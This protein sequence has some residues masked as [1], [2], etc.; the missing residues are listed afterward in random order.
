[1]LLT[2]ISFPAGPSTGHIVS[3]SELLANVSAVVVALIQSDHPAGRGILSHS[4]AHP[5]FRPLL[6]LSPSLFAGR[7]LKITDVALRELLHRIHLALPTHPNTGW[8]ELWGYCGPSL[9]PAGG[10]YVCF[11][12]G[13]GGCKSACF[14]LRTNQEI[15]ELGDA[16][17]EQVENKST[18]RR[19][20]I[21]TREWHTQYHSRPLIHIFVKV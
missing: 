6:R 20:R 16:T 21:T 14:G 8:A 17:Q 15:K 12:T 18:C 11:C 2:S 13:G 19:H 1:M 9:R 3:L 10:R 5:S 7:W 4:S